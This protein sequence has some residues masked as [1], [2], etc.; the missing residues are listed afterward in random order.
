MEGKAGDAQIA[1]LA[2]AL[3]M[4]RESIDEI[5]PALPESSPGGKPGGFSPKGYL[6]PA[7]RRFFY[8]F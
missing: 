4:K 1:A 2:I 6:P 5:H 8:E 7:G 3:R